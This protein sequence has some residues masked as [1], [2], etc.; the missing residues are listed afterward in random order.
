[1]G[2]GLGKLE[3]KDFFLER[4]DFVLG[5]QQA[6]RVDQIVQYIYD[7][8]PAKHHSILKKKVNSTQ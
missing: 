3:R 6:E 5:F 1:V 7:F 2:L 4:N 8:Y